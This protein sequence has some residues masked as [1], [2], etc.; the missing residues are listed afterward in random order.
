MDTLVFI[1]KVFFVAG[2]HMGF[3]DQQLL[4]AAL[5]NCIAGLTKCFAVPATVIATDAEWI[6][7]VKK[8]I[9][10]QQMCFAGGA[11]EPVVLAMSKKILVYSTTE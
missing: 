2:Q 1:K 7:E 8:W 3:A 6:A 9:A 10:G 5:T 4:I 11:K